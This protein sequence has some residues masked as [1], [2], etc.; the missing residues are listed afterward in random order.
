[1]AKKIV[2]L[3]IACLSLFTYPNQLSAGALAN[4]TET[5]I[6]PVADPPL[7]K[8]IKALKKKHPE[9][10]SPKENKDVTTESETSEEAQ[11]SSLGIIRFILQTA[12]VTA[13]VLLVIFL[14]F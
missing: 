11:S 5:S 9:L 12:L 8:K 3:M 1:M 7:E 14:F 6:P 2:C 13:L 10:F 4:K